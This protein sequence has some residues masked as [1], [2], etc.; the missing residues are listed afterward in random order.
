MSR[1]HQVIFKQSLSEFLERVKEVNEDD[2]FL[3]RVN[4]VVLFGSYLSSNESVNDIDIAIELV[5]KIT[6]HET[7][8]DLARIRVEQAL[9]KGRTFRD[10]I[11]QI[12]WP[13]TEVRRYLKARSR[14]ISLHDTHEL[15]SLQ[16]ESKVIYEDGR[17]IE[18]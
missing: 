10:S 12:F 3:F 4:K 2:Y 8:E 14:V 5:C 16:C 15:L 1:N 7:F 13:Q 6:D 9:Q 18:P 11:E 17:L